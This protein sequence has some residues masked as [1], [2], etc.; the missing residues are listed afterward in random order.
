MRG[1]ALTSRP[2]SAGLPPLLGLLLCSLPGN[3]R[4]EVTWGATAEARLG[5]GTNPFLSGAGD[6][7]AGSGLVGFT[8]APHL[9]WAQP[10]GLTT[11]AASYNRD[12]YFSRYGSAD[13]YGV[14]LRRR[15]RVTGRLT[16]TADAGY[17]SSRSGLLSTYY[18]GVITSP[19]LVDALAVGTRQRRTH[20]DLGLDWRPNARDDLQL[21]AFAEHDSFARIPRGD[22]TYYGAT[23]GDSHAIDARTRVGAQLTVSRTQSAGFPDGTSFQPAATVQRTLGAHWTFNGSLGAII[24]RQRVNGRTRSDVTPGFS[25]S[26]CHDGVHSHVCLTA[27]RQTAPSGLGGLR[28]QTQFGVEGVYRLT[29]HSRL[30]ASGA[31]GISDTAGTVL[32]DTISYGDQ[33]YAFAR[34]GYQRDLSARLAAGLNGFYQRRTGRGLPEVHS[35]AVTVSLTARF[36]HATPALDVGPASNRPAAAPGAQPQQP[37]CD[38][39]AGGCALPSG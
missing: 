38:R 12:Q 23:I 14:D 2:W 22:Y 7:D 31:Y 26:F 39:A 37:L 8:L 19:N 35:V 13:D 21:S 3:A 5:Y 16:A 18:N 27:S 34:L 32:L 1:P 20:G 30:L 24:Q 6:N 33:R 17:F 25:A 4:A 36:G 29:E 11:L 15:Q 28:R 9:D 10:T